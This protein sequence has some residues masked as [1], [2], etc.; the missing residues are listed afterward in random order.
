MTT[1]LLAKNGRWAGGQLCAFLR[2][3]A[4]RLACGSGARN[5]KVAAKWSAEDA[6]RPDYIV[7][8]GL[9]GNTSSRIRRHV[10]K[11]EIGGGDGGPAVRQV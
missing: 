7:M 1:V 4:T 6:F 5:Y 10:L 11:R 8:S 2:L 9:D 3:R